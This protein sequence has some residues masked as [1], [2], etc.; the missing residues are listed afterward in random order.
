MNV[1]VYWR[2]NCI[3]VCGLSINLELV[4]MSKGGSQII[5]ICL[6][7]NVKR[8]VSGSPRI[9]PFHNADVKNNHKIKAAI[10]GHFQLHTFTE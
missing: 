1:K 5:A 9:C 8:Q 7:A 4:E 3:L 2:Q 6:K 10:C